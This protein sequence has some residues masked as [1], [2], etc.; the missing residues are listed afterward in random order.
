M[1]IHLNNKDGLNRM[2]LYLEDWFSLMLGFIYG[3]RV[4]LEFIWDLDS[5]LDEINN[6]WE[7][8]L[9]GRIHYLDFDLSYNIDFGLLVVSILFG[10][11]HW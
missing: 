5:Y 8:W 3:S 1:R 4:Q 11:I 6:R 2:L 10:Y 7:F 9:Y